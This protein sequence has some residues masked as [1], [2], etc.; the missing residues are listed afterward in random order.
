MARL[1]AGVMETT[2]VETGY[3]KNVLIYVTSSSKD[4][5]GTYITENKNTINYKPITGIAIDDNTS[6]LT[7]KNILSKSNDTSTILEILSNNNL[8]IKMINE[9]ASDDEYSNLSF[10]VSKGDLGCVDKAMK[11]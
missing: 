9:V 11:K 7:I 6:I 10:I 3:R 4:T 8:E 2:S 1:G 5:K